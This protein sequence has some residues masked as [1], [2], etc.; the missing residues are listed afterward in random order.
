MWGHWLLRPF[1]EALPKYLL[2]T[3]KAPAFQWCCGTA[4]GESVRL[5]AMWP[6]K[7]PFSISGGQE[8]ELE[9]PPTSH[10]RE[11]GETDPPPAGFL[12]TKLSGWCSSL[13]CSGFLSP[14][15]PTHSSPHGAR[16]SHRAACPGE[17]KMKPPWVGPFQH[18]NLR[19]TSF[20]HSTVASHHWAMGLTETCFPAPRK[21]CPLP[22]RFLVHRHV[23]PALTGDGFPQQPS[24][25][26]WFPLQQ[27]LLG[28]EGAARMG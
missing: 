21:R 9:P 6:A 18:R 19:A 8:Q 13:A 11:D 28:R 27:C 26:R 5:V 15:L 10:V 17:K 7:G 24:T 3:F 23:S 22:S 4:R 16:S 20:S 2:P 14:S 12:R 1:P 25:T